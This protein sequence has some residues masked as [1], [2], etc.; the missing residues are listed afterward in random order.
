MSYQGPGDYRPQGP[1][2]NQQP[3][4]YVPPQQQNYGQ[5]QN[6]PQ[7]S[8][9]GGQPQNDQ[10]ALGE[11][12]AELIAAEAMA[13][14]LRR[15]EL[16]GGYE[17]PRRRR[18][19]HPFRSAIIFLVVVFIGVGIYWFAIPHASPG[20]APSNPLSTAGPTTITTSTHPKLFID[21]STYTE[22]YKDPPVIQV[23][24]GTSLNT[25]VL[26][27]SH[28]EAVPFDQTTDKSSIVVNMDALSQDMLNGGTLNVTVP[29]TT[30]LNI[31]VNSATIDISGITG[32]MILTA[33]GGK[34]TVTD[35]TVTGPA[36]LSANDG[37]ITLRQDTLQGQVTVLDNQGAITA[38]QMKLSGKVTFENN[39]GK[40]AFD[41]SMTAQ[42]S[43]DFRNNTGA[44][45]C[46]LPT[47]VGLHVDATTNSG[48]ISSDDSALIVQG[49]E[50]HGDLG[51]APRAQVTFYNNS[52][53]TT[54]QVQKG[55]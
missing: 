26:K 12:V 9:Y 41:G 48:T 10:A 54:I 17:A 24:V 2:G 34:I 23:H 5:S 7:Q 40:L 51:G 50:L 38:T 35:S 8:Y 31:D 39:T 32:A 36:L 30:N 49:Q 27:P 21:S 29:A 20:G 37:A 6:Y 43:Y 33:N 52:G 15:G 19:R 46:A 16:G 25:I 42:G 1:G 53:S 45:V 14:Q 13:K 44:I 11:V 28:A 3:P 18:R 4:Y 47:G 55:R 22:A